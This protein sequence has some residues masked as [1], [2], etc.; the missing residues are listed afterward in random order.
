MADAFLVKTLYLLI[1][2]DLTIVLLEISEH[3]SKR[4]CSDHQRYQITIPLAIPEAGIIHI[5]LKRSQ[6]VFAEKKR[7][8]DGTEVKKIIARIRVHTEY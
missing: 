3:T 8:L 6:P 5:P 4:S 2:L 7:K 1:M